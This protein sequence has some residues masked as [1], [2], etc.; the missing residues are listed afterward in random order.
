MRQEIRFFKYI[1][2]EYHLFLK[3]RF[4]SSSQLSVTQSIQQQY[5]RQSNIGGA[6]YNISLNPTKRIS[7][8]SLVKISTKL[9]DFNPNAVE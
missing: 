8:N 1:Y 3:T 4:S 6:Y 7:I 5:C 2:F 9:K